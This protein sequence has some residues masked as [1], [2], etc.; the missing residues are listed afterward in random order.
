M[1]KTARRRGGAGGTRPY[2][3]FVAFALALSLANYRLASRV[4]EDFVGDRPADGGRRRPQGDASDFLRAGPGGAR[5]G[6][7]RTRGDA[8]TYAYDPLK[9]E[10]YNFTVAI[11]AI[12]KDGEGENLAQFGWRAGWIGCRPNHLRDQRTLPSGWTTTSTHWG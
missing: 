11:C 3:I 12:V 2:I 9:G 10:R 4:L 6:R 7:A 5:G 1:A 8:R